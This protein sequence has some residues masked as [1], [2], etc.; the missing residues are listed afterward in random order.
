MQ[1]CELP[2]VLSFFKRKNT[3]KLILFCPEKFKLFSSISIA[4]R[5]ERREPQGSDT[6]KH[7]NIRGFAVKKDEF[8]DGQ[9]HVS[10]IQS[11]FASRKIH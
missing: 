7:C 4:R 10:L 2:C 6:M 3:K 1:L 9:G 8:I 11:S 5:C